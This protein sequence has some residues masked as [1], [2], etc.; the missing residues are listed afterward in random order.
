VTPDGH[1]DEARVMQSSGWALLDEASIDTVKTCRF[2]PDQVA[3]V[4]G[5]ELAYRVVWKLDSK[6]VHPTLVPGSCAPSEAI[7]GFRQYDR[8]QTDATGVKVRFLVDGRGHPFDVKME[9]DPD[10]A[11]AEQVVSHLD[12]CRFAFG[13]TMSGLPSWTVTGR[14]LLR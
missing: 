5:R 9:G 2:T 10:A 6:L 14:V 11:L 7:D 3:L 1:V 8:R 4:H 12:T 13:P